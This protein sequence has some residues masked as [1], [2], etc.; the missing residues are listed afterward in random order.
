M[1]ERRGV[2][3]QYRGN[4][5]PPENRSPQQEFLHKMRMYYPNSLEADSLH[6]TSQLTEL[7]RDTPKR[8]DGK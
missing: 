4:G 8:I 3:L 1:S 6:P 5:S 7:L 2:F